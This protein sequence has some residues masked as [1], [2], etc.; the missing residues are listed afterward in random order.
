MRRQQ[1][2]RKRLPKHQ[3]CYYLELYVD[4]ATGLDNPMQNK[5]SV[6]R[7]FITD[8]FG[9]ETQQITVGRPE[10]V[11]RHMF[12]ICYDHVPNFVYLDVV[13]ENCYKNPGPGT[14]QGAL[15]RGKARIEMPAVL[16][17]MESRKPE[18]VRVENCT[19]ISGGFVDLWIRLSKS[20]RE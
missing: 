5:Y 14:S 16:G 7:V 10:P 8:Q 6:Y 2:Q 18:L 3:E 17:V 20:P 13:E 12:K 15:L 9:F 4:K 11:W 1:H 19:R